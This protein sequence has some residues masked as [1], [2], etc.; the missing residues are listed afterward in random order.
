MKSS[1]QKKTAPLDAKAIQ[2]GVFKRL[3]KYKN[4]NFLEQFAM[5][6]GMG[7]LLEAS[8]KRLLAHR[9]KY[10]FD[11]MEKWTLGRVTHELE[12]CG[13]RS[14][15]VTLL[16][17]VVKYRNHI[18]HEL[19][20]NEIM[21]RALLGGKAGRLESRNLDKGIYELEQIMFLHDWTEKH[22]AWD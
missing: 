21:L 15:F 12:R 7:Q 8:L 3:A 18:A 14:D 13:L 17:S 19:L 16:K 22:N 11:E 20:A 6:M 10:D 9:Y 5:F 4:L 1:A 2:K